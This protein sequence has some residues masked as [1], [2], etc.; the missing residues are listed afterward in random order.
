MTPPALW[1][2]F[3]SFSANQVIE[4]AFAETKAGIGPAACIT[5]SFQAED[6]IVL[7]LL[8]QRMGNIPVL[9]LDTGYH[10]AETYAYRDR[11]TR[12]WDLN[13]RNLTAP[14]SVA[15][16]EAEFGILN[17]TDPGRCCHLRKVGPLFDA[18]Q[19]F[20]VWFTG[21]RREQSATR[22]NLRVVES[23]ELP[24]GKV[25]L[26]VSPLAAWSWGQ[27]WNYTAEHKID[28]L[29][30]YDSGYRSIGC[31]PC[32]SIS[33]D[34]ADP[35]SGRWGGTKLECGIHTQSKRAV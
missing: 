8:R 1:E 15:E 30:L 29:P 21:L 4:R 34:G 17:R 16:Q 20:D 28:H 32:T 22:K 27:V 26:K 35:R 31:E 18:L 14:Q 10:F 12:E 13:L 3:E 6:M 5:C 23:H 9:F 11:M 25:L 24:T 19:Q 2:E 33:K 7:H